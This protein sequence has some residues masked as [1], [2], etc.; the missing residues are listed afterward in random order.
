MM[1]SRNTICYSHFKFMSSHLNEIIHNKYSILRTLQFNHL[2]YIILCTVVLGATPE[3]NDFILP[4]HMQISFISF[5]ELI[6]RSYMIRSNCHE[7]LCEREVP[8]LVRNMQIVPSLSANKKHKMR[9]TQNL[10][11]LLKISS[12][13]GMQN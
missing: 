2:I 8:H 11:E 1:K 10:L 9:P 5:H 12:D 4:N 7:L 6:L 13:R 3:V